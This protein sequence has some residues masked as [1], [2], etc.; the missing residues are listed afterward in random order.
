MYKTIYAKYEERRPFANIKIYDPNEAMFYRIFGLQS[1]LF[2]GAS[3]R[4]VIDGKKKSWNPLELNQGMHKMM[5]EFSI[6]KED[7]LETVMKNGFNF[8]NAY[9]SVLLMIFPLPIAYLFHILIIIFILSLSGWI[10]MRLIKNKSF[11]FALF[12]Y[13]FFNWTIYALTMGYFYKLKFGVVFNV[14][15]LVLSYYLELRKKK[16]CLKK[17][18]Y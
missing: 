2:W 13:Q 18:L 7:E 16:K 14:L 17:N 3:E 8:T 6:A 4:Y 5:R 1:H 12:S 15:I 11:L 10:L 9:P